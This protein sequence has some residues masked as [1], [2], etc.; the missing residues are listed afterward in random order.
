MIG[1]LCSFGGGI[2]AVTAILVTEPPL[3]SLLNP[4]AQQLIILDAVLVLGFVASTLG[5][6]RAIADL[7][8]TR[9]RYT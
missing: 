6:T 2:G 5:T 9:K 8:A 3:H 4:V 1:I 7:E